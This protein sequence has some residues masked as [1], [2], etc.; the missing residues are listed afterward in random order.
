MEGFDG[1][2]RWR[3]PARAKAKAKAYGTGI[4]FLLFLLLFA[5]FA[6]GI[7]LRFSFTHLLLRYIDVIKS[8]AAIADR[9]ILINWQVPKDATRLWSEYQSIPVP[10]CLGRMTE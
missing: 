2:I 8:T 5:F 9:E 3:N 6:F 4:A 1:Q 10:G 7:A